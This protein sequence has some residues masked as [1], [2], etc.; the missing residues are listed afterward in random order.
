VAEETTGNAA[1]SDEDV[2]RLLPEL[3]EAER[4]TEETATR[5]VPPRPGILEEVSARRHQLVYGRRG[6]GTPRFCSAW[7]QAARKTAAR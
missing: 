6:V 2:I 5:F 7:P 1:I 4:A 3:A